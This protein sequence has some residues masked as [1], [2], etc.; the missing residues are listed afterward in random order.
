LQGGNSFGCQSAAQWPVPSGRAGNAFKKIGV[1]PHLRHR[2]PALQV[3]DAR[4]D[5]GAVR[6]DLAPITDASAVRTETHGA[7]NLFIAC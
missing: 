2:R 1:F 4:M 3:I 7:R 6:T 5:L